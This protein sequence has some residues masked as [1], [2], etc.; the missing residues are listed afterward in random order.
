MKNK[1]VINDFCIRFLS[2]NSYNNNLKNIREEG[3]NFLINYNALIAINKFDNNKSNYIVT[4]NK[5]YLH[6]TKTT[7]S[8]INLLLRTC[9]EKGI[10]VDY[11]T[12]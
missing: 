7:Q 1:D 2:C 4:I 12:L 6:Y 8:I 11:K 10:E 9:K 3:K 5:K